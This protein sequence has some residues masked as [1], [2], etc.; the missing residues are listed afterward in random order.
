MLKII[1]VITALIILVGCSITKPPQAPKYIQKGDYSY[2]KDYMRWYI[3]KEMTDNE[4]IG[5][6][7]ALVDDQKIVWQEGFGYADKE[8][9]IKATP[10]TKYRAGSITK[11]FNAIAVMKLAEQAKM[12]I[13]KPL[14][15]YLPEFSVKSR[16]GSTNGITP[17]TIM[18]HHSGLPGDWIDG[19][20]AKKPMHYSKYVEKIQNEYVAYPPNTILAY[21]N[22]GVTLLGHA[23]EKVS[24]Q[25]YATYLQET[26]L[27]PLGMSDSDLE[28]VL[29]GDMASKSYSEGKSTIEYPLGA[30]PAGALNTTVADLS[31]LIMMVNNQGKMN[32]KIILK[33]DTLAQMLN[34][35]NK[36]I[37]FDL[38]KKIG[39]GWFIDTSLL[40]EN[41]PVYGHGG[42]TIAH[43]SYFFS[44]PKSKLGVVVLANSDSANPHEIAQ[45]LL[46]KAWE[47][48]TGKKPKSEKEN[49]GKS[50][51]FSGTFATRIGKVDIIKQS[52]GHFVAKTSV[53]SFNLKPRSD[54]RYYPKYRWLGF[55]PI[56]FSALDKTGFFVKKVDGKQVI[57]LEQDWRK[58]IVGMK[59]EPQPISKAWGKYLGTYQLI[60][61]PEPEMLQVKNLVLKIE[62]EYLVATSTYLSG[63][64]ISNILFT[65]NG[66]EAIIE[67]LWRG[68]KETVRIEKTENGSIVLTHMGLKF[69]R[70]V[71]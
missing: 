3:K 50:S 30:V 42:G 56:G 69:K 22:L 59:V 20:F 21:S 19:M 14:V 1:S 8:K 12:D 68:M 34:V 71:K 16:F 49:I 32:G 17:R 9:A 33:E 40:S 29:S 36:N 11:V 45:T 57:I 4:I 39:L 70:L 23:V 51:D 38:G 13:D 31:R 10:K 6:S 26:I 27:T 66:T 28:M 63:D 64:K 53:G 41:D 43:K 24:G 62:D 18:T 52:D 2:L 44:E 67:G 7:I 5:L 15:T 35:Q 55:I 61:Q 48:K 46:T 60:N 54:N 37:A 65:Q 47:A 25:S 58:I